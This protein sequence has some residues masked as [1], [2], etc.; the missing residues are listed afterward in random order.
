MALKSDGTVY[1]WGYNWYGSV[2]NGTSSNTV[3]TPSQAIGLADVDSISCK[4]NVSYALKSDGT[5]WAWGRDTYANINS[6]T[7][8][9]FPG[10]ENITKISGSV[11]LKSDGTVWTWGSNSEGQLG[12][13]TTNSNSTPTAV[14][15][16]NNVAD[17]S[18]GAHVLAVQK[19]GSLWAWGD[20]FSG[21][22]GNRTT[23]D[24]LSPTKIDEISGIQLPSNDLAQIIPRYGVTHT[25]ATPLDGGD[26]KWRV[27]ATDNT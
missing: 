17:I 3:S 25:F 26:W 5:I 8:A 14:A 19:D 23:T 16:L 1:G 11:A 6:I 9:Q 4:G 20:N 10:L 24:V 7:P 2:G 15:D 21:Q 27:K 12:D 22:I 13:G 18:G